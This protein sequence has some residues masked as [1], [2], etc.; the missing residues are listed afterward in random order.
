VH[1]RFLLAAGLQHN[2]SLRKILFVNPGEN[3]REEENLFEIL[4]RELVD[5]KLIQ[6]YKEKTWDFLIGK[7][8]LA[9]IGRYPLRHLNEYNLH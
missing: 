5:Q 9:E 6:T 4:H 7:N 3:G 2:I 8:H 1:F